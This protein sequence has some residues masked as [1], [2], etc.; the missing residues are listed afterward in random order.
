M[1]LNR[2]LQL[3]PTWRLCVDTLSTTDTTASELV[4]LILVGITS[5]EY[6]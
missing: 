2:D 6:H 5:F 4:V 3:I 1:G